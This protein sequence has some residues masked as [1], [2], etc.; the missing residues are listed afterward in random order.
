V[1]VTVKKLNLWP[2]SVRH[3]QSLL[4]DHKAGGCSSNMKLFSLH[5]VA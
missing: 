2:I 5:N 1:Y 3:R 4:A